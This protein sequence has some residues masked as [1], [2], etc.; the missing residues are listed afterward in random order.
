M[1][2]LSFHDEDAMMHNPVNYFFN[3]RW[4]KYLG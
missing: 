4:T 1:W 2:Y 3:V